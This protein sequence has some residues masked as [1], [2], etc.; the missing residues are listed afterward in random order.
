MYCFYVK[1]LFGRNYWKNLPIFKKYWKYTHLQYTHFFEKMGI[2]QNINIP[3]KKKPMGL[4]GR[5]SAMHA[6]LGNSC[7]YYKEL[8]PL[9]EFTRKMKP[10]YQTSLGFGK[11]SCHIFLLPGKSPV[12]TQL[13]RM[14][15]VSGI[16]GVYF[17][18]SFNH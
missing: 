15:R 4:P 6:D 16:C 12:Y 18:R 9:K 8:K 1:G 10:Q 14:E 5:A 3:K 2:F 7:S 17:F 11:Q 13:N